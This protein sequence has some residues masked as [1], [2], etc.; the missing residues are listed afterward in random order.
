MSAN[1]RR[2]FNRIFVV[3]WAAWLFAV[4]VVWPI[5][6]VRQEKDRYGQLAVA[7]SSGERTETQ[8][9]EDDKLLKA[10]WEQASLTHFYR[11]LMADWPFTLLLI[12]GVPA[13][14]YGLWWGF[15]AVVGW[16]VRGFATK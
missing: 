11:A 16:V 12:L 2:G 10:V 1:Y 5:N 4:L 9:V 15:V 6:W 13:L 14:V 7:L 8:K 3:L